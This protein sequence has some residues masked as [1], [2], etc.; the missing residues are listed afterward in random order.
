[1]ATSEELFQAL[2]SKPS[3][4]AGRVDEKVPARKRRKPRRTEI[5]L[6]KQSQ[7]AKNEKM[8][9]WKLACRAL[10]Y[11]QPAAFQQLPGKGTEKWNEI[12]AERT[13]LL[14]QY[15]QLACDT[16]H[17]D[18]KWVQSSSVDKLRGVRKNQYTEEQQK[19]KDALATPEFR[20]VQRIQRTLLSG[21]YQSQRDDQ[22]SRVSSFWEQAKADTGT[23]EMLAELP[24]RGT[25]RY[26][27]LMADAENKKLF[28]R[29]KTR[30]RELLSG[31]SKKR[32]PSK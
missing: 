10:G 15:W 17:A 12:W 7:M 20:D 11:F 14:D 29:T 27:K 1:M 30:H 22:N 25:K 23:T 13:R 24:N 28:E 32:S 31:T 9:A 26:Q 3:I 21:V 16:Q 19:L 8:V 6:K 5:D 2:N 4:F 18:L